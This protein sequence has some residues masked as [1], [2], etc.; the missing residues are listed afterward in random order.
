[1]NITTRYIED[2][3]HT[4]AQ[5]E[6]RDS[7]QT[8]FTDMQQVA[9]QA[10]LEA[11]IEINFGHDREAFQQTVDVLDLRGHLASGRA[12]IQSAILARGT[13]TAHLGK[14][15]RSLKEIDLVD[16]VE[17]V[18]ADGWEDYKDFGRYPKVRPDD[19]AAVSQLLVANTK[20]PTKKE[21]AEGIV[22]PD[23][24]LPGVLL[25][26]E[27][28]YLPELVK[29]HG[30]LHSI[31]PLLER[32]RASLTPQE[33]IVGALAMYL[34]RSWSEIVMPARTYYLRIGKLMLPTSIVFGDITNVETDYRRHYTWQQGKLEPTHPESGGG[35][36]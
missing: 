31:A 35:E 21:A 33:N 13:S 19:E 18:Q 20:N 8:L 3:V 22:I 32:L 24:T 6:M 34:S 5:L 27:V 25:G 23:I 14:A 7:E 17:V 29:E 9:S 26:V 10:D 11:G 2:R 12:H 30:E 36:E 16:A 28:R 15:L 4:A 1:M